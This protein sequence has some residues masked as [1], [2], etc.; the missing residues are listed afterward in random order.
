MWSNSLEQ[1]LIKPQPHTSCIQLIILTTKAKRVRG[2]KGG[3]M[4]S[5]REWS[6]LHGSQVWLASQDCFKTHIFLLLIFTYLTL[7]L[8]HLTHFLYSL[9]TVVLSFFLFFF[10]SV[11]SFPMFSLHPC[12]SLS[13][14]L[15]PRSKPDPTQQWLS[16]VWFEGYRRNFGS[17]FSDRAWSFQSASVVIYTAVRLMCLVY[18]VHHL[19]KICLFRFNCIH[20]FT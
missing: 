7:E 1:R 16:T 10:L 19:L 6:H 9:R 17:P 18:P 14:K 3:K 20:V 5:A 13:A 4:A 11:F 12:L 8:L 2:R 15:W